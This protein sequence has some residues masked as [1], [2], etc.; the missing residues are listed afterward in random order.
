[1]YYGKTRINGSLIFPIYTVTE[2]PSCTYTYLP[3]NVTFVTVTSTASHNVNKHCL[4]YTIFKQLLVCRFV[5]PDVIC[6]ATPIPKL[7]GKIV[8]TRRIKVRF[9]DYFSVYYSVCGHPHQVTMS[10]VTVVNVAWTCKSLW[11]HML[12]SK[13]RHGDSDGFALC[14]QALRL[15]SCFP[16]LRIK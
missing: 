4:P 2:D 11:P 10:Q 14:A 15:E 9:Y 5:G 8:T 16:I 12:P 3:L 13:R 1:M 7:H 6:G